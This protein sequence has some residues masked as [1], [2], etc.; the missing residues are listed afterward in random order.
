MSVEEKVKS[1]ISDQ[2]GV[3]LNDVIPEA[4]FFED[5]GMDSLDRVELVMAL[6]EEFSIE[7]CD[8]DAEK[9]I[10]VGDAVKYI[11]EKT[12]QKG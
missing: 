6:E 7:I 5:L 2:L 9:L 12:S 10:T 1:I 8:E 11:E 4:K 3:S